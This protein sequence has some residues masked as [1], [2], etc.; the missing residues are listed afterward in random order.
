MG[1]GTWIYKLILHQ[2]T[3]KTQNVFF[4]MGPYN[5][6][7]KLNTC[8]YLLCKEKGAKSYVVWIKISSGR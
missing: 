3:S 7:E 4:N 5:N 6:S 2:I 8:S 1:E